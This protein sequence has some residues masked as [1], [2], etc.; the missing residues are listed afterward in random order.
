MPEIPRL[1]RSPSGVTLV[2]LMVALAVFAILVTIGIPSFTNLIANNRVTAAANELLSTLQFARSEAVKRNEDIVARP[3][4][5]INWSGGWVVRRGATDLRTRH[6]QHAS[7]TI[8]KTGLASLTFRPAGNVVGSGN[9]SI[10]VAG[11]AGATRCLTL[12]ASGRGFVSP[13]ACPL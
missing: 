2:E 3:T 7:V 11:S 10:E 4:D 13:G 8:A 6:A 5:G 12:E 9:F 1:N